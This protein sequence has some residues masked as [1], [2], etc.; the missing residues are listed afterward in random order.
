MLV[1]VLKVLGLQRSGCL[2]VQV[3][4]P[5]VIS[6]L[7]CTYKILHKCGKKL[8][9]LSLIFCSRFS[10]TAF[11]TPHRSATIRLLTNTTMQVNLHPKQPIQEEKIFFS[12]QHLHKTHT[13]DERKLRKIAS[14]ASVR[15]RP[16]QPPPN[17]LFP[18]QHGRNKH[19]C[20]FSDGDRK[21]NTPFPVFTHQRRRKRRGATSERTLQ[22]L[23]IQTHTCKQTRKTSC[24]WKKKGEDASKRNRKHQSIWFLL[25][26][27]SQ[28]CTKI[29]KYS[30]ELPGGRRLIGCWPLPGK[31]GLFWFWIPALIKVALLSALISRWDEIKPINKRKRSL[32]DTCVFSM[33][34]RCCVSQFVVAEAL[35]SV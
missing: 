6:F 1:Q 12:P 32:G 4:A 7:S 3:L 5:V 24:Q 18:C 8:T 2:K 31:S 13:H 16:L 35:R 27:T 11:T 30:L 15:L 23:F 17:V 29:P 20:L 34:S 19:H 25:E 22:I 26:N 10:L 28:L 21:T 33:R 9:D 14:L